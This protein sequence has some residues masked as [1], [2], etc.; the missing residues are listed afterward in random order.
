MDKYSINIIYSKE[1]GGYIATIPEFSGL[2]A[3]GETPEEAIEE[4]QVALKG[5]MDVYKEDGCKIPDPHTL[6]TYSGQTRLR[7]PKSLHAKLSRQAERE[8]ISLNTYMVQLLSENHIKHQIDKKLSKIER[9]TCIRHFP[10]TGES[11]SNPNYQLRT[12]WNHEK[13]NSNINMH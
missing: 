9:L 8:E 5:F 11:L 3:Y 6:E 13:N 7:L 4:A 10:Q 1:D 12:D 2:S